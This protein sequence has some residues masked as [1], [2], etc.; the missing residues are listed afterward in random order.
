MIARTPRRA[1]TLIELLVV[2]AIIAVL[3]GLLLSAVQKV[4]A[5]AARAQCL[6]HLK[7]LALAMHNHHDTHGWFPTGLVPVDDPPTNYRGK[8]NLWVGLLPFIEQDNLQRNWDLLDYR[9]NIAGGEKALSA[10]VIKIL[11]CPAD[12]LPRPVNYLP[13]I[14][15][16]EWM[17]G[18]YA[19]GSYGGNGGT[20]SMSAMVP[21]IVPESRDGVFYTGSRVRISD[22]RDG[23]STTVLLG[24][25]SH[26]DPLYDRLTAEYEPAFYP[27]ASFGGWAAALHPQGSLADVLLGAAVPIN[28]RVPAGSGG[29]DATWLD[30]RL[31]AFGSGHPGGANFAFADGSV[32]FVRDSLPLAQLRALCTIAGGEVAE[33]P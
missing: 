26:L 12:P 8:T 20:R 2:I 9:R 5:A 22:I 10:Q 3:I 29:G 17:S 32:R 15:G 24:E 25:R 1:F 33:V 18:H 6:N 19:I 16:Y 31:M 13:P 23:T 21:S 4:R 27:L 11:V 28:Y 30:L 7:Q 14:P